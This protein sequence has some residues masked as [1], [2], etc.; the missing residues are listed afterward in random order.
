MGQPKLLLP[1]AGTT[2][3]G[4]LLERLKRPEI[5]ATVVVIRPDDEPLRA[6]VALAGAIPLIP[7]IAPPEMRVSIEHAL[8]HIEQH[9]APEPEEG[10]MLIP[11]D[12]PCLDKAVLDRIIGAWE[13]S[14][15][16]ILLPVHAGK[17]GHPAVFPFRLAAEVVG[18]PAGTGLN[19][20]VRRHADEV[21]QIE[22][23]SQAVLFDLDTP[24]DYERLRS[25]P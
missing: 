22:V 4:R 14:S 23:D 15:D 18:L 5:A 17:R 24:D 6:A 3:I 10:W 12:H 13:R 19:E 8:R 7:T 2:V 21:E 16:K 1:F 25:I 9:H 20:L 11:A